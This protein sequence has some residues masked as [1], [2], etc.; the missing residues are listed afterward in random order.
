MLLHILLV[1]FLLLPWQ[2]GCLTS[3]LLQ[4]HKMSLETLSDLFILKRRTNG[5]LVEA[6]GGQVTWIPSV[7]LH[8]YH[9]LCFSRGGCPL[10]IMYPNYFKKFATRL[11]PNTIYS[12]SRRETCDFSEVIPETN[13][14]RKTS[15]LR[16][17]L[18]GGARNEI[19]RCISHFHRDQ[20]ML[21]MRVPHTIALWLPEQTELLYHVY[22]IR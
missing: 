15:Q 5:W 16:Q 4:G 17:R 22:E 2:R 8:G 1:F 12:K 3:L 20:G 9:I 10:K 13:K 11:L 14:L 19:T 7:L 18:L 21:H 6:A